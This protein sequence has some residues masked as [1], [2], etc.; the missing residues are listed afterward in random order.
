M[1]LT[2]NY[3]DFEELHDLIG[4]AQGHYSGILVVRRDNDPTRDLSPK[5]IVNA[6]RKLESAN[7]PIQ[8]EYIVLNHW[9]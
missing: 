6:I 8:D 2:R 7:V 4:D 9:R 1:I 5:G 3:K